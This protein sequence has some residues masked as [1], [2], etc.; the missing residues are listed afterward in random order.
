MRFCHKSLTIFVLCFLAFHADAGD[1]PSGAGKDHGHPAKA[2][3]DH[4]TPAVID[5][6]SL[7]GQKDNQIEATGNAILRQDGQSVSADRLL[8]QQSTHEV[9]A[10]GSVVLKQ[11]NNSVSGPRLLFNM[12]SSVGTMEQPQFNLYENGARGSADVLHIQDRL[13]FSMDN[14]TYTTCPAGNQDWYLS[15]DKLDIDRERQ[16]GT[17][18][19]A[20]LEFKGVPILYSPWMDFALN[21]QSKS[22]FLSPI[23][24]ATSTGGNELTVPYYWSIARN[25]DATIAP[26]Y[27][28]KRGL[29]LNNEFRYLEPGYGGVLTADVLPNDAIAHHSREFYSLSHNQALTGNLTGYLNAS[30]VG[31]DAYFVDLSNSVTVT[32][33]VN[34]LQEAGLN[35]A[36]R[37]WTSNL[38]V[39]RF[40]TL[41]DPAAPIIP[42]YSRMPQL[43]VGTQHNFFGA[44]VA[45]AGE[46]V[47]YTHPTLVNGS[48]L[49]L[50]P[51]VSY[52]LVRDAAF[53][54][55][56]KMALHGTY[57]AMGTNNVNALPD[58][59][60]I[61]PL[62]SVD[63]GMA[64]ER[65]S[66]MFSGDYL[67][68]LEPRAYYVYVPY[69]D[70]S[71][72]PDFDSALADFNFTQIFT[73]NRFSGSDRIGDANQI[74]L[75]ATSRL[76]DQV[77][78]AERL[79]LMLG[80]RFSF[81][82]PKVSLPVLTA[83]AADTSFGRS[84]ILLSAAGKMSRAWS[85]DSEFQYD[86][87]QSQAQL[88]NAA[89]HYRPEAGKTLNFGYRF[90]RNT[91]RQV[92]LSTQ[93][94]LS[95]QWRML[96][97][98]NY[99]LQDGQ[100]LEAIAGL[101]YTQSCWALRFVAQRFATATL[102]SNTSFF[103][104][105]DLSELIRVG[106]DPLGVLKQSI[107]GYTNVSDEPANKPAQALP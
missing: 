54:V 62:F 4:S 105:L 9:D 76:L 64:F 31:D 2:V 57:Y 61:L 29:M 104:Q 106:S 8:Y 79:K 94:P 101:E 86:P 33:Q 99:S 36:A 23:Y 96:G 20:L 60:R 37:G 12:D 89:A 50:N 27:M 25:F 28:A 67:Q 41:Q 63:S 103:V 15:V 44:N 16:I 45:F 58:A 100:I 17:A 73:E 74:T 10:Q 78:G 35:Y 46:Y 102:Q 11:N 38:R 14:A 97:R 1:E 65:E 7:V 82:T 71:A 51:S 87:N 92:D 26:R 70:Q 5:A 13:H 88:F 93:W 98:W 6:D 84:D 42:P 90:Q 18:R 59:T 30:H 95:R 80:E 85:L 48:R 43:T 39:Q 47:D 75:A 66:N 56:P 52:P 34:L 69:R 19:G 32:S 77:S 22:G 53:Y 24:G 81:I 72:L 49:V 68:T 107:P 40:Q 55:T 21:N 83:T 91:L 3:A